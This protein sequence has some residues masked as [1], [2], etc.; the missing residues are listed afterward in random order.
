M[1]KLTLAHTKHIKVIFWSILIYEGRKVLNFLLFSRFYVGSGSA[2]RVEADKDPDSLSE[3]LV[4]IK[5]KV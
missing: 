2:S 5:H 3:Y 4:K 1:Y